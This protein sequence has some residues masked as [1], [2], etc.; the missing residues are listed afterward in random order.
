MPALIGGFAEVWTGSEM[1][2]WGGIDGNYTNKGGR[3]NPSTGSWALT[4]T[5]LGVP[6]IRYYAT[7]VWTGSEMIIFGGWTG[8]RYANPL[9]AGGRYSPTTDS[10]TPISM[11][12][13]FPSWRVSH[14]AVWTG[15]EMIVWG[16][17][18]GTA[19]GSRYCACPA[20]RLVYR[21]A[22]GDG[23]GDAA[24]SMPSC[25]GSV[26]AGYAL[27]PTDCDDTHA[28][29]H[30]G[31]GGPCDLN[32]GV[33]FE[34]RADK[35]SVLWQHELGQETWNVYI[36]DLG[37][38]RS[39]GIYTQAAGSNALAARQCGLTTTVAND[40]GMPAPGEASFSLVTGVTSGIE[41]SLG[42]SSSGPRANTNPCP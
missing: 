21:D 41:G 26:P 28:S 3:Y 36:G 5:G 8:D 9:N 13:D 15:T 11:G 27:D 37:V 23:F 31:Q 2:V 12:L 19:T 38:L 39:T 22:D 29:V 33:I 20:G 24:V 1:I 18:P 25:D 14:T 32:D 6:S 35:T 7:G 10:W 16:G 42:P 17:D 30:P 34:W 4:S 40:V